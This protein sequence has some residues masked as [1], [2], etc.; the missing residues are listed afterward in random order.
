MKKKFFLLILPFFLCS[1]VLFLLFQAELKEYLRN[2]LPFHTKAYVSRLIA[3]RDRAYIL[4]DDAFIAMDAFWNHTKKPLMKKIDS[5]KY[6]SADEIKL[7]LFETNFL[8]KRK[9]NKVTGGA[10]LALHDDSLL[11]AQENGLFFILP[12]GDLESDQNEIVLQNIPSNIF[13][14]VRYYDFYGP[15]QYGLKGL[16]ADNRYLFASFSYMEEP[17][18]FNTSLLRA[19]INTRFLNFEIFFVPNQCVKII[20]TYGE[21]NAADSGGRI[22]NFK[23]NKILFSTGSFRFRDLAQDPVSH[24]GKIL[25]ID[26]ETGSVQNISMGHR[27]VMGLSFLSST[28]EI[29]STEHG[30][31]GGDEINLNALADSSNIPMNYG[32]PISSYGEHYSATQISPEGATIVDA[33]DRTYIKAPLYKSHKKYG[34]EEPVKYFTP[35]IG[36]SA[37]THINKKFYSDRVYNLIFG[38]MGKNVNAEDE[39][40]IFLFNGT[41][42]SQKKIFSGERVRDI[43]F[44]DS[45]SMIVFTGETNG[46]I[47]IIT[48]R[49][50]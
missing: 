18:C 42:K 16:Y 37:I 5:T 14:L 26:K 19:D 6:F 22:S 50:F 21:F 4:K 28:N 9:N 35:S 36:I 25:S 11:I 43:L 46:V 34:F 45:Q 12:I 8:T 32:W 15:G 20:N 33:D 31:N 48:K 7:E 23:D 47:G 38:S 29:W 13:S 3:D 40:S 24:L 17:D 30:P 49:D 27:N 1:A 41:S 39:K 44:L 10:Y 2:F